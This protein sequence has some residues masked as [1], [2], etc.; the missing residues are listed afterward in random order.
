MRSLALAILVSFP[1]VAL[2]CHTSVQP[3]PPGPTLR[4]VVADSTGAIIPNAEIDLMDASG[5][6]DGKFQSGADGSFQVVAPHPGAYTL[7]ISEA[8]FKTVTTAVSIAAPA[9]SP[10]TS[11]AA[12]GLSVPL[13]IVLPIAPAATNVVVSA[14]SSQDL[15]ATDDNHDSSVMTAQDLKALPIFDNDFASAMGAFLDSDVADTGGSGLMVDGVEANR[16]TVSASAVQEVL[17]NQDP[18]SARYYYPGRGQMEIITKSAAQNFHG[19]LNFYFRDSA[20]NAQN[21]LAAS[22][23]YEQRRIYE[24]SATGPIPHAKNSSFLVSFNRAE[25]DQ[26]A[27]VKAT[28]E[29]TT[30][31]PS[32]IFQANVPT[33]TRDTE[34][35]LRAAHQF[36]VNSAYVQYSYQD[37]TAQNQGVGGQTLASVG[38]NNGYHE[39][40]MITHVVSAL[41]ANMLNQASLVAEHWSNRNLDATEGPQ[42]R[43]SG[44]FVGGSAQSDSFATEYNARLSDVLTWTRGRSLVKTGISIPHLS[45][46][47]FDDETNQMGT[48]TYGPTLAAD[49]VTVQATALDNYAD[50]LPSGFSENT[51]DTHFIYHQQEMGAFIQD[52]YKVNGRFEITPGLRYDWQNFLANRRLGFS[53]RLSFAW[54][55]DPKSKTIL[56]G[57]GGIYYDRFGGGPLLDLA[58]YETA[59]RESFILSLNPANLP[60]TGCV[61]ISKCVTLTAPALAELEPNAKIPYQMHYGLSLERQL[62]ERATGTVSVY[63]MRGIDMFRSVDIN[64]PTPQSGFTERPDPSYGRIRQ[65][66][67]GAFYTGTGLDIS[68]RGMWN[69]YFTG[70][71]RYTWSHYESNTGGIGW[72]P[73]NQYAPGDEWS[74]SGYDRAQRLG[75][76]AIFQQKSL[77]NL[78]AGIFANSGSPW[79]VLT[80][81][82]S[83]GDGLFN[84]RPDDV[85]RNSEVGP[86]YVDMDLRWGHDFAITANK[87]DE[88]PRLGF[89]AA[90]FNVLNHVNGQGIDSVETSPQ[91]GEVTSVAPARRIQLAMRFEF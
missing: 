79:T 51:G 46:R 45:R 47:A 6:M 5:A 21:A 67:A 77:L 12:A 15:T 81:A 25:Q 69:K 62:G 83:Y 84:A 2:A 3:P 7:V 34:F 19:E 63:Q 75:M 64:A 50:N 38:Y 61:P 24:G 9:T 49:G 71:G 76:Y 89:S 59:R 57:G 4:G 23:P 82:D 32:G 8:G 14:D 1:A 73:E 40:D 91:F 78:A 36:G 37:A 53:P 55:L 29:P 80:G 17:I 33:P 41:S 56:R 52:Q 65:M 72:F 28:I 16:V 26:D 18:Y 90:S 10:R 58:R 88:A 30:A 85:G 60:Q 42:V 11:Q 35:S 54:V 44:D 31:D 66:Q 20:L 27:V 68:Y 22:K 87:A 74:N 86:G 13:H 70:F 43:L 48:Y 39:D